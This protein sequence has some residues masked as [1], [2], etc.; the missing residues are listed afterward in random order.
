MIY[1]ADDPRSLL[2]LQLALTTLW[3]QAE[4]VPFY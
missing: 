1:D 2:P 3:P 4:R